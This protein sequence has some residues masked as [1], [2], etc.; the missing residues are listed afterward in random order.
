MTTQYLEPHQAGTA[1]LPPYEHKLA[2]AIEEV[3]G[4]GR[5]TLDGLVEGLNDLGVLAPDGRAWTEDSLVAEL[6]RLG[7]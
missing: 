3:F 4:D 2:G 1:S 6:H 7:A 5:H